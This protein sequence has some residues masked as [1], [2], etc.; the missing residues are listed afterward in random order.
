MRAHLRRVAFT[1]EDYFAMEAVSPDKH[2]YIDGE[3]YDMAG[4]DEVHS[5][6]GA[7][8]IGA[9]VARLRGGRCRPFQSDLRVWSPLVRAYVYP[10]ASVV[11]G[12]V[13]KY[14]R[15]GD[16]LSVRNPVVVVEVVSPG[17]EDYDRTDK[18]AI[19]KAIP[20][21]RDYLIVDTDARNV[22][23]HARDEGGA[24]QLTVI[25]E[26][27]V[28]LGGVQVALPLA[29]IFADLERIGSEASIGATS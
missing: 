9:L 7:N 18:V 20:S 8:I 3:I 12:P 26:G 21:L 6:V 5:A 29:E 22:E 1:E 27:E 28:A 4:G 25:T 14:K 24:W 19:Y 16:H 10:D 23:H 11:C 15:K 13:E 2:E 17:T